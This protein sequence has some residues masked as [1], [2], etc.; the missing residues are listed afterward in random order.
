MA[1]RYDADFNKEIRRVVKNFNAKRNRAIKRGYKQVPQIQRVSELKARYATKRELRSELARLEKF[2]KQKDSL[3]EVETSGGA[4]AIN[5]ELNYL[6]Q[7]VIQAK[8][9]WDKRIADLSKKEKRFPS[10]RNALDNAIANRK[11]LDVVFDYM[12]QDQFK[13]LKASI[14]Q[15]LKAPAWQTRNYRGFL[16]EV[17]SVMRMVGIDSPR[18]NQ[19]MK[20][21]EVLN[22]DQFLKLYN[23]SDLIGRVYDLADSPTKGKLKLNIDKDSAEEIIETLLEEQNDLIEMAQKDEG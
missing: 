6:K 19:F 12:T 16:S 23:E 2:N 9:Y 1:V 8:A 4:T 10:E 22:A 21:F 5:W 3:K 11:S 15:S 20:N 17:E 7:N 18:I 13:A 14:T